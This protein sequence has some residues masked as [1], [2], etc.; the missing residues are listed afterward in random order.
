MR[1]RVLF[2][3]LAVGLLMG[4]DKV[5]DQKPSQKNPLKGAWSIVTFEVSG[6][7][8]EGS[9]GNLVAFSK[10]KV[11]VKSKNGD[12]GGTYAIRADKSP[13]HFDYTPS[14]GEEAGKLHKGIYELK[15]DT[16]KVLLAPADEERPKDFKEKDGEGR[17]YV[18]LKR[19]K[20]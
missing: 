14:D 3:L 13:K 17:V 20:D 11:T 10:G 2:G 1:L 4:A 9:T 6:Q 16:L 8:N 18:E 19:Q 15:G 5:Q 12:H 7:K